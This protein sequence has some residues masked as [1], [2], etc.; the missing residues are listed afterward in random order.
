MKFAAVAVAVSV[1]AVTVVDAVLASVE[2]SA[3]PEPSVDAL[4]EIEHAAEATDTDTPL[5]AADPFTNACTVTSL[6]VGSKLLVV[7][8]LPV[9]AVF[10]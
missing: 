5:G 9:S 10:G 2:K 1:Q 8:F 6:P 4:A 3:T 7:I